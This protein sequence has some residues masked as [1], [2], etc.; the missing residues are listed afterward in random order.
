MGKLLEVSSITKSFGALRALDNVAL[1]VAPGERVALL[2]HNGAGK[3]TL[4]R[5]ILGF[6]KPDTGSISIA[7]AQ[8]GSDDARQA[9][10]YLPESVAF[11]ASLTGHEILMLFARLKGVD[12]HAVQHAL[13][14]VGLDSAAKRRVG[15]YSKGMRQRLGLAQALI[16]VPKLLLL[17]EPTSGL[18]PLSRNEFYGF[19]DDLAAAGAAVIFSS[20]GLNEVAGKTDRVLILK[21][22]RMVADGTHAQLMAEA[23]LP[24]RIRITVEGASADALSSRL[25][26]HRINGGMVE[27]LCG[28]GEKLEKMRLVSAFE[29]GVRDIE[30]LKPGLDDVY[31]YF[32][33]RPE[34]SR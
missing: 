1:S 26:G 14:R 11:P 19:F 6:I 17:D 3:T 31:R 8:P 34:A 5:L 25:G 20:H 16:S 27:V 29:T 2:G 32:S 9:I 7:G 30:I 4:F 12:R 22:G 18:D 23:G 33:T 13:E 10:A 21:G 15:T 28:A 24:V